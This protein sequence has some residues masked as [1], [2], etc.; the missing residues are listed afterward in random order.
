M[1]E[2]YSYRLIYMNEDLTAMFIN[3]THNPKR[4]HCV[5]F[6]GCFD[7]ML[8]GWLWGCPLWTSRSSFSA[9]FL[10]AP[11]SPLRSRPPAVSYIWPI[12]SSC[13]NTSRSEIDRPTSLT[14]FRDASLRRDY[15]KQGSAHLFSLICNRV[16]PHRT[17]QLWFF[18]LFRNAL[19][20]D[21]TAYVSK[22]H[23]EEK[24]VPNTHST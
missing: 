4:L 22:Y 14:D 8:P 2:L 6:R 10:A 24:A 9:F 21:V 12:C 11:L 13:R 7:S 16:H 20:T 18:S 17:A 1:Y 23:K 5:E 15:V 19:Q 3:L